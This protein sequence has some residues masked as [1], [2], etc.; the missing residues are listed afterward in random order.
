MNNNRVPIDKKQVIKFCL[1]RQ[2]NFG[3]RWSFKETKLQLDSSFTCSF[4]AFKLE[5]EASSW[6]KSQNL[7]QSVH[8]LCNST[9][10]GNIVIVYW[11]QN[12]KH[13]AVRWTTSKILHLHI[14][15][16][17]RNFINKASCVAIIMV[18]RWHWFSLKPQ[19]FGTGLWIKVSSW[20][21]SKD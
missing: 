16:F 21:I 7:F 17:W 2:G 14:L 6:Q 8:C 5:L 1:L 11:N 13:Y 15:M 4:K 20:F 19:H 3:L 18:F 12:R 9:T 10:R